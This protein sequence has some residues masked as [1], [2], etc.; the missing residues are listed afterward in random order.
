MRFKYSFCRIKYV[1]LFA[2]MF[3]THYSAAKPLPE[4][5]IKYELSSVIQ[6]LAK[7]ESYLQFKSI[8][9][10]IRVASSKE[11]EPS[12]SFPSIYLGY[13]KIYIGEMP[14]YV[15]GKRFLAENM[16]DQYSWTVYVAGSQ[17]GASNVYISSRESVRHDLLGGAS[18]FN[19]AGLTLEPLICNSSD[20]NTNYN[21]YYKIH[22]TN[23]ILN[24]SKSTGSSGVWYSYG[25][26]RLGIKVADLDEDSVIGSS[27]GITD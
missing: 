19:K 23:I 15:N 6:E 14:I 17:A 11:Q 21:A 3:A 18:Y 9:K 22:G 4:E 16:S 8:V 2:L 5:K 13:S 26:S 1:V 25:I 27:C 24:I 10:G 7:Y 20:T 12:F